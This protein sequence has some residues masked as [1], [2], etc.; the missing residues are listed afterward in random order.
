[1]L[2]EMYDVIVTWVLSW[3]PPEEG[4]PE[5]S[6]TGG[7]ALDLPQEFKTLEGENIKVEVG[8]ENDIQW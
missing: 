1:M 2:Q 8:Y 6:S 3:L 5:L 4:E 7:R